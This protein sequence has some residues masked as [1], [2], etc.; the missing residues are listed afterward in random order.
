[1]QQIPREIT[2]SATLLHKCAV[3]A[4]QNDNLCLLKSII[5]EIP[6]EYLRFFLNMKV[7]NVSL[8]GLAKDK[9]KVSEY[10][11]NKIIIIDDCIDDCMDNCVDN[12]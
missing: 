4:I 8:F 6:L 3:N 1:M 2:V 11:L 5:Y 10:L 7:N 12:Y 9:L